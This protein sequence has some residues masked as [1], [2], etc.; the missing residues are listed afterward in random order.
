[1]WRLLPWPGKRHCK[2]SLF[3][4]G[5]WGTFPGRW[6]NPFAMTFKRMACEPA[7][8]KPAAAAG[9]A[10]CSQTPL[11]SAPKLQAEGPSAQLCWVLIVTLQWKKKVEKGAIEQLLRARHYARSCV[12]LV[13]LLSFPTTHVWGHWG[14]ERWNDNQ[15]SHWQ[16]AVNLRLSLCDP[17]AFPAPSRRALWWASQRG[18]GDVQCTW[19]RTHH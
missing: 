8:D 15:G 3:A 12:C 13:P 2:P 11:G 4:S 7:T 5:L 18:N 10:W 14:S 6:W 1:M 17:K 16:H 19:R 9:G